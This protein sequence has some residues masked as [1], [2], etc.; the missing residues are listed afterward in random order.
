MMSDELAVP[1][2][3]LPEKASAPSRPGATGAGIVPSVPILQK[4]TY[5][6]PLSYIGI[7]R[8]GTAWLRGF[9]TTPLKTGIGV[10]G[11]AVFLAAMYA[12]LVV[13]YFVIFVLFG[14]FAFPYRLIRRSHRK[15]EHLQ[16]QQLA[17]M[18]AM[19]VQQQAV[20]AQNAEAVR[21]SVALTT[22]DAPE[23]N[24]PPETPEEEVQDVRNWT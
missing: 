24:A 19:L 15:Q 11:L 2:D 14:V 3:N 6:S 13:W 1:S 21:A 8:R 12:F 22:P 4:Q 5:S 20:I 18:Q 16:K 10:L 9:G 23:L 17:T 7:T